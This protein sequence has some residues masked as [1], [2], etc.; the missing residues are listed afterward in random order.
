ML[1]FLF[2]TGIENSYPC[3]CLGD[4]Q[5][6]RIDEM[7][8]CDHYGRWREDF[9]LVRELNIDCLRWGPPL[10]RAYLGPGRYDWSF[11]DETLRRLKELGITPIV[12]LC[13][14]GV[15]DWLGNFQN[16]EFPAYFA[17]YAEA[18]A[19]RFSWVRYFTLVNE[20]STAATF[21]ARLGC[22]NECLA[23]DEA[24]VRAVKHMCKA[25]VL[26]MRAILERQPEAVFIQSESSQYFHAEKPECLEQAGFLNERRFL[27]LDLTY[28]HPLS[29]AL[30]EY[31]LDHGMTRGEYHWFREHHVRARCVM[32]NDYY[33][34]N[35]HM[36]HED[37]STSASGEQFGYY[38]ITHQY[39]SRYRLPVMHTE[40][41]LMDAE[42]APRWLH[43][44]WANV[45]RL[46]Q[47]GVPILGFTW[48]SLT[49][50]V[51]WDSALC[52][53]AGHVNPLGLY[54]LQRKLRPVGEAYRQLIAHW[55]PMLP[56]PNFY[57]SSGT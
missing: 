21:S 56:L 48:Y 52:R 16:P 26:A 51:D 49:D 47:D 54:D 13:H 5:V 57:L 45:Y 6:K 37:G 23:S 28:G 42:R 40:T 30:Y 18:F 44:E 24:F 2:A 53:D 10:Y 50:Q 12:D 41:N 9:E 43:K 22:W 36:V 7:E 27:A 29:A 38:V 19:R 35:E 4:Q 31:L 25:T 1:R 32:G 3:V 15:P 14:F 39:Y 11:A 17:E 20:I 8:K 34:T 46:M 33:V 55:R